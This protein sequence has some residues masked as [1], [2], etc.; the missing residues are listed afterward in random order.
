[1]KVGTENQDEKKEQRE[2]R[3]GHCQQQEKN[4]AKAAR[5]ASHGR[6]LNA[7]TLPP[8]ANEKKK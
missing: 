6:M 8:T 7:P 4:A 1:V 3:S 2:Q 5:I